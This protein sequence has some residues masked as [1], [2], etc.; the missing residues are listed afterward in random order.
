VTTGRSR[1]K[2]PPTRHDADGSN[3]A[4]SKKANLF[5]GSSEKWGIRKKIGQ[6]RGAETEGRK[7]ELSSASRASGL[8]CIEEDS[9]PWVTEG[10]KKR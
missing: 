3:R 2:R 4:S 6:E 7:R 10:G 9:T 1:F 5:P 8:N